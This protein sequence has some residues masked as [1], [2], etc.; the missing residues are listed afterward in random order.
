MSDDTEIIVDL[1]TEIFG[2][3]KHS[4]LYKEAMSEV[5]E[6]V[7]NVLTA[8]LRRMKLKQLV[9]MVNEAHLGGKEERDNY[10]SFLVMKATDEG[11]T[12][13][14]EGFEKPDLEKIKSS[15]MNKNDIVKQEDSLII[16]DIPGM[17]PLTIHSV[18][19]H[20]NMLSGKRDDLKIKTR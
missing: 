8:N 6:K 2:K 19:F 18:K 5:Y 14:E 9:D 12:V 1:L 15:G 13:E 7:R 11:V 4:D 20:S 10:D 3:E 17:T 16:I